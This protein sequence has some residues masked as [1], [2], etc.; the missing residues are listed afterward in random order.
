MALSPHQRSYA[1][2][3]ADSVGEA[4]DAVEELPLLQQF[5]FYRFLLSAL[6]ANTGQNA[7]SYT[8]LI[9]VIDQTSSGVY[10]S[11]FV[12][13]S[14]L[15]VIL[16]G[17]VAGVVVDHLPNKLILF[18][19]NVVRAVAVFMLLYWPTNVAMILLTVV[20][21]WTVQ[22]FS[23]PA[24]NSALPALLKGSHRYSSAAALI[25]VANLIAQLIGMVIFAPVMLKLFGPEPVYA[26]TAVLYGMAAYIVFTIPRMTD[27]TAKVEELRQ[28]KSQIKLVEALSAG[29][30]MLRSDGVAFQ[31]MVQYTLLGTATAILVVLVPQ[32]TEEVVNTSA[33]NLI[34]IFSPAALGLFLGIWLA[35]VLG[36]MLGNPVVATIGFAVF[37]VSIAGFAFS[38]GVEEIILENGFVPFEEMA[39]FF[40]VSIAVVVTMVLAL[41]A[42]L[43]AGLVG[44]A[45]KAT[46]LERAPAEGRGRIFAT[47]SWAAG[48]LS[49]IPIFVAGLISAVV[50]VRFAIFLLAFALA[51]IALYARFGLEPRP[52]SNPQPS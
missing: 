34:Y 2:T 17:L 18:T 9:V 37:V 23:S 38:A 50:D 48:V 29:W 5:R 3:Y 19:A 10:T 4:V 35:P 51:A 11:L 36:R 6:T 25:D 45:A 24:A 39:D 42:G 22:Q 43:G 47:Q 41:P 15:P 27:Q 7:L 26:T 21:L 28:E 49:L 40:N 46:L 16:F 33:E 13:C 30:Q 20:L 1:D 14:L 52:A 32:Y 8:L 31:A 44:I 12:L